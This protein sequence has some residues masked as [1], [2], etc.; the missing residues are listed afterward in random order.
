MK[1]PFHNSFICSNTDENKHTIRYNIRNSH[2]QKLLY[3][4]IESRKEFMILGQVAQLKIEYRYS[5]HTSLN[6]CVG[7]FRQQST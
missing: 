1:K 4:E 2:T 6:V 5:I 7:W 3:V